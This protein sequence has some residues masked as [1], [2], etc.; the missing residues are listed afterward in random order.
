VFDGEALRSWL[1][2]M[3]WR[4]LDA[5]GATLRVAPADR[6]DLS[7]FARV[8]RH[9]LMLG[10]VSVLPRGRRPPD[11]ARRLLAVNRDMRVAKFAYDEDGDVLLTAE[12]PT[13][14]LDFAELE[15]AL[16]RMVRYAVHYR[17][18]LTT[19]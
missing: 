8:D 17:T 1:D 13:E 4:L 10:I 19:P 14:S 12:L 6:D 5:D 3:G 7:I 11:L 16:L 9:W 2:R 15:D 18:Y